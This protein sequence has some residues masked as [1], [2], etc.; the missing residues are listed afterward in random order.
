MNGES[1]SG[2]EHYLDRAFWLTAPILPS[3]GATA[4]P[5]IAATGA[6]C[7]FPQCETIKINESLDHLHVQP[8]FPRSFKRIR[9]AA[10]L[11]SPSRHR[12]G[13]DSS[14]PLNYL[15]TNSGC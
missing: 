7:L 4:S 10:F 14:R 13:Q 6:L 8:L 3:S 15:C 1:R 9:V 5:R 2:A 12:V 11:T